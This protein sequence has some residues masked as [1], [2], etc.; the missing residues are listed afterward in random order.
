M[1]APQSFGARSDLS[2]LSASTPT[3]DPI[4]SHLAKWLTQFRVWFGPDALNL[5]AP[6]AATAFMAV[7]PPFMRPAIVTSDKEK[8]RAAD[9]LK[10]EAATARADAA[11]TRASALPPVPAS[12][13]SNSIPN[14]ANSAA[15]LRIQR[16]PSDPRIP[17]TVRDFRRMLELEE[18]GLRLPQPKRQFWPLSSAELHATVSFGIS[19]PASIVALVLPFLPARDQVSLQQTH[20]SF[21]ALWGDTCLFPPGPGTY[22][23]RRSGFGKSSPLLSTSH[24]GAPSPYL[25][26]HLAWSWLTVSDRCT[27]AEALP[28]LRQYGQLRRAAVHLDLSSLRAA[29]LATDTS[30]ICKDRAYHGGSASSH[31]LP[32]WGL[33]T[34]A[35]RRVHGAQRDWDATFDIVDSVRMATIPPTYPEIDF[36]R[37]VRIATEGVPLAGHFE[38]SFASVQTRECH[39]NGSLTPHVLGEVRKKFTKEEKLSYHILFPRFIWAFIPGLF[40][41]LITW[42]PPKGRPGDDGRMCVDP[43][44]ILDAARDSVATPDDGAANAQLP[45]TGAP[46]HADENPPAVHYGTAFKRFL[47]W[48]YNL[49]V[50][51]PAVDIC[52]SADDINAAFRRLLYHPDMEALWATVFQEFLVIPCGMIF[53]GKNSPSFYMIAGELRAHLASA[54]EFG[55]ITTEL[56]ETI[57]LSTPLTQREAGTLTRATSDSKNPGAALLRPAAT[58]TRALWMTPV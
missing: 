44:T 35:A 51:H 26:V 8:K 34:L 2:V 52:L 15:A 19:L 13:P 54:G 1:A 24:S 11:T 3:G 6:P 58:P 17:D 21:H 56:S 14:P 37:A 20:T 23:R 42:V 4:H 30:P 25:L 10:T 41:A 33:C 27:T 47:I 49:R 57:S 31:Q 5:A 53:G 28:L 18:L 22:C 36:D 40:L 32:L 48:I 46:D 7:I 38:N 45:D 50:D 43:S 29:R 16:V 9:A 55:T 39:D 12:M